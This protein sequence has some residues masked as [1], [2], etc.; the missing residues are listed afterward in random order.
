MTS[1]DHTAAFPNEDEL[2][3]AAQRLTET[4]FLHAGV[5]VNPVAFLVGVPRLGQPVVVGGVRP[6][7]VQALAGIE[8]AVRLQESEAVN[9]RTDYSLI[10]E[11]IS[12]RSGAVARVVE[13]RLTGEGDAV[14]YFSRPWKAGEIDFVAAIDFE[15]EGWERLPVANGPFD[16]FV[17]FGGFGHAIV[18]CVLKVLRN[19]CVR[20]AAGAPAGIGSDMDVAALLREA[21]ELMVNSAEAMT[22]VLSASGGLFR[23]VDVVASIL[24]E[25]KAAKGR[26]ILAHGGPMDLTV[27]FT[28]P[29][30]LS[31]GRWARKV[32]ETSSVQMPAVSDG[33]N[34]LGLKDAS[35]ESSGTQVE[36]AFTGH[37]RW[38]LLVDNKV[39]MS[40][41]LGVPAFPRREVDRAQFEQ[42]VR[43]I[44]GDADPDIEAL[45]G[46]VLLLESREC[47]ATLVVT[48]KA[49]SEASRLRASALSIEPSKLTEATFRSATSIDGAV[50][51]DAQGT[52]HALGVILDGPSS[53]RE[54]PARGSRFNS[55][56]RYVDSDKEPEKVILVRSEDG[57]IDLL[58]VLRPAITKT[59]LARLIGETKREGKFSN[60]EVEAW[61]KLVH[62]LPYLP[63]QLRDRIYNP[64]ITLMERLGRDG[65]S[66]S[67]YS[68]HR[69]DVVDDRRTSKGLRGKVR[70]KRG[71]PES[72]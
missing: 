3:L 60:D 1:L 68:R 69:T 34:I 17:R 25:R 18:H 39:L 62:Y 42:V 67:R 52:C 41:E 47:G 14:R 7:W 36:V 15:R 4:A 29:V 13:T 19:E 26:M 2:R 58:P 21:G 55:A 35:L 23:R 33:S 72:R 54:S 63:N 57:G 56:V 37:H 43:R 9:D 64:S 48:S 40:C 12:R 5:R 71:R 11:G 10:F 61:R 38:N 45:W 50:L 66:W 65:G 30:P 49:A 6:E 53:P 51:L 44:L 20:L 16:R 70:K 27:R 24:Y 31:E 59:E 28:D 22:G 32:L 8:S 46:L